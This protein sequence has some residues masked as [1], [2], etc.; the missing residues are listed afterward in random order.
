[1]VRH[2]V[3]IRFCKQGDLR[4]IG[5]HDLMRAWERAFRRA[6]IAL[7]MSEGFRPKPRMAFASALAMGVIGAEEVL[8]VELAE[9]SSV[10]QLEEALAARLPDGLSVKSIEILPDDAPRTRVER[11]IYEVAIPHDRCHAV[12]ERLHANPASSEAASCAA[13]ET[14]AGRDPRQFLD[15]VEL[16]GDRLRFT[17][18]VTPE[19][20]VRP[21]E[22]LAWLGLDDLD[23]QGIYLIRTAVELAT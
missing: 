22:L 4:L 11:V 23:E 7:R 9:A 2:R 21:R 19:G 15:C 6:G 12:D 13:T 18:R 17:A 16:T 1:M 10:E 14:G 5:H 3:R 8:D 20:T